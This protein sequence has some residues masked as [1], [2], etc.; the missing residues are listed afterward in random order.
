VGVPDAAAAVRVGACS[1]RLDMR[2]LGLADVPE[3]LATLVRTHT[4]T[5][6]CVCS[7]Y[8]YTGMYSESALVTT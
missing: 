3:V 5:R 8:T 4:H 6:V 1:G 7:A 2:G